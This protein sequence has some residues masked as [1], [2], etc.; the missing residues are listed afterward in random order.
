MDMKKFWHILLWVNWAVIL[1]FWWKGS[2]SQLG[3]GFGLTVIALGRL[4]GLAAAYYILRQ[5]FF[6]GRFPWLERTFG[7]DQLSRM[8]HDNGKK[9]LVL[10]LVHPVLIILGYA[11]LASL[12]FTDQ[13]WI[14]LTEYKHILWA[15]VGLALFVIVA[16]SSIFLA[17]RNRFRYEAWY[18]VHLMAYLAVFAS[19]W[20]QIE[21]GEDLV[22]NQL[23]YW[24]WV[25]LY[26]VVFA[27][28]LIFR[29]ARP[30]YNYFR[31]GFYVSRIVRENHNTVSVY[32]GGKDL[33]S[34]NIYPGQFMILRFFSKN[35]WWQAHPFSL[36]MVPNG[37]ELRVTIKN[38]G[39]FTSQVP[40][41]PV[42]TRIMIDGPYGVF[43]EF[44]S[45]SPKVLFIAGGI[46][47]T[48]I[49]SLLE[50]MARQRK[51][52]ALLYSNRTERDIVFKKELEDVTAA[53][54][55]RVTHVISD[56][57]NYSGEKGRLDKEK[58]LRLVPDL[59]SREVYLCGPVPMMN[60]VR[61]MLR[62]LGLAPAK[63][64]Y[65]EFSL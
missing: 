16:G 41:V 47:I 27:N 18:F 24:Y 14:F 39:D 37:K 42:G 6:M 22:G 4:A 46:G 7:L 26:S 31:H 53:Y 21:W 44:F 2:G 30:V 64:H 20:H 40:G 48:P 10:L 11:S 12:S 3:D 45:V 52:V 1:F 65:E 9:G 34:F 15:L 33:A 28:H 50:A 29:F 36:S 17:I 13:L 62:E 58:I 5:F 54:G 32:V 38:V 35:L 19:F 8:H 51:D 63:V 25:G 61:Q 55:G 43:T 56:D 23:F 57:P 60:A 49:R 59:A